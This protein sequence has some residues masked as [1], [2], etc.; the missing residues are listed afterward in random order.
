MLPRLTFILGG[1]ASGKSNYA[2][3]LAKGCDILRIYMATAQAFDDEMTQ[4]IA[5]HRAARAGDGWQTIEAPL[6][7][8]SALSETPPGALVLVDCLTLWLSNV[9]LAER[10]EAADCDALMAALSAHPGPL[11]VVSNETGQGIVPDTPLGRRFRNAQGRLNQRVAAEADLAVLVAAGLPL[12]LK[13][14]VP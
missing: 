4:K 13:G 8:P 14:A 6:D 9:L 10:D 2:E 11:I 7:L 12:V 5:R 1:A 3:T